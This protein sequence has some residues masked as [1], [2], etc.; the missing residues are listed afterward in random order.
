MLLI[1]RSSSVQGS[2]NAQTG[3]F[4]SVKY[5]QIHLRDRL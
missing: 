2:I 3:V 5:V 4:T 1:T